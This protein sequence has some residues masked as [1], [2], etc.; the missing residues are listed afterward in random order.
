MVS[1]RRVHGR[2][3]PGRIVACG[4]GSPEPSARAI[5]LNPDVFASG[6][7]SG[8][9]LDLPCGTYYLIDARGIAD[10]PAPAVMEMKQLLQQLDG[11][12]TVAVV[13]ALG[14]VNAQETQLGNSENLQAGLAQAVATISADAAGLTPSQRAL[15]RYQGEYALLSDS[16]L[17]DLF[18]RIPAPYQD[19]IDGQSVA[20]HLFVE[21][22]QHGSGTFQEADPPGSIDLAAVAG[23]P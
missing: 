19:P 6:T 12:Q 10:E 21:L 7:F 4:V 20:A 5:G 2:V 1:H 13:S 15:T 16:E 18:S 14:Q 8:N 17:G 11:V 9:R 22:A 3:G 23:S